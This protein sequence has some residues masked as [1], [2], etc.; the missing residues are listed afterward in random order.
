MLNDLRIPLHVCVVAQ[1]LELTSARA[2]PSTLLPFWH[3]P[4][5]SC[6]WSLSLP[7][8]SVQGTQLAKT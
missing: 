5:L 4:T 8:E 1:G 7:G 3:V 6:A 2:A